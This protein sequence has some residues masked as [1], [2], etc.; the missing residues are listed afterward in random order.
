WRKPAPGMLNDL[1]AHW[2]VNREHSLLVGDQP[3]DLAAAA[4]AGVAGVAFAGGN[5]HHFLAPHL[6]AMARHSNS[7]ALDV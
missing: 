4:A 2:P 1:M 5:L 7:G 6:A 3:S